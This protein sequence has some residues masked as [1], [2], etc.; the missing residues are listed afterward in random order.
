[1]IE[2]FY[3]KFHMKSSAKILL[4]PH[5]MHMT[6]AM[7]P[8]ISRERNS[9]TTSLIPLLPLTNSRAG[10]H[11]QLTPIMIHL[12]VTDI[13]ISLL[14]LE[15][16]RILNVFISLF[17]FY[18]IPITMPYDFLPTLSSLLLCIAWLPST[19]M[20]SSKGSYR[21]F[22]QFSTIFYVL[23]LLVVSIQNTLFIV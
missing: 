16:M 7:H 11:I 21:S 15:H 13:V 12:I 19:Y 4:G 20:P 17:Y 10:L 1:M 9:W 22:W 3:L 6:Q 23:F 5:S 2:S 18:P 8:C 14:V